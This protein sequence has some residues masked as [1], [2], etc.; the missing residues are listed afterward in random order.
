MKRKIFLIFAVALFLVISG[1]QKSGNEKA[2]VSD[3]LK[4]MP[5]ECN[6]IAYIHT[7]QINE[8]PLIK[9]IIKKLDAKSTIMTNLTFGT[10]KII[11]P[12]LLI[13]FLEKQSG[14]NNLIILFK[15]T[16]YQQKQIE[17]YRNLLFKEAVKIEG[18]DF[19][20]LRKQLDK[21]PAYLGRIKPELG[22]LA[23]RENISKVLKGEHLS[24][25]DI[26]VFKEQ[27]NAINTSKPFIWAVGKAGPQID[28]KGPVNQLNSL[29]AKVQ[30]FSFELNANNN[31]AINAFL[32]YE[33]ENK[34][35]DIENGFKGILSLAGAFLTA[36]SPAIKNMLR[37]INIGRKGNVVNIKTDWDKKDI[38]ELMQKPLKF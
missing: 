7:N 1:C 4:E 29:S 16:K 32:S 36:S 18:K 23:T 2:W 5:A 17:E 30:K 6:S 3:V 13:A 33:N 31:L 14:K 10:G 9:E 19:L 27:M 34:A 20:E 8:K 28:A 22:I 15:L 26:K 38:L 35:S 25:I 37:N 21:E 24:S 11:I 12:D